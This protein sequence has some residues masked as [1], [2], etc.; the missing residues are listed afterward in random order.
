M[1]TASIT[2][3]PAAVVCSPLQDI[4]LEQLASMVSSP[5]H[6]PRPGSDDPHMGVDLADRL[7][8]SQVAVSGRQINAV[9]AGVVA[10]V[11]PDRF[12]YGRAV[13]VETPLEE[14]PPGWL[15]SPILPTPDP[16]PVPPFSL[17]CPAGADPIWS[18]EGRSLYILYAH[19][20]EVAP[21]QPGDPVECGGA[22]GTLGM[23]GN[24]LNPHLHLEMRAGP[25]GLRFSS[26]AHYDASASI[27]EM[28][29]YCAW[30]IGPFQL[31]DPLA[32][33]LKP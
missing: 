31:I 20:E 1:Q 6:P 19:L 7:P 14:L 17:T 15:G 10:A 5:Y 26:M 8:E 21:L 25:A 33:L 11:N 12:P 24:A 22:L 32:L 16:S 13:L 3:A 28:A 4:P 30:R 29:A 2:S 9:L 23:S 27:E 18:A